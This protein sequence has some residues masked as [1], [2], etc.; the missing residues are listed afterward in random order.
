MR[1]DYTAYSK[2][3]PR[4]KVN[5]KTHTEETSVK[6]FDEEVTEVEEVAEET[7]TETETETQP[8]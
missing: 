5:T 4:E 2:L 7:E 6:D 1:F 8:E 3:Y